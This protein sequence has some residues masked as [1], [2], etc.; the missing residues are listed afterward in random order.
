MTTPSTRLPAFLLL[1]LAACGAPEPPADIPTLLKAADAARMEGDWAAA[2]LAYEALGD[3]LGPDPDPILADRARRGSIQ[4]LA[5]TDAAG[6]LERAQAWIAEL[7]GPAEAGVSLL[8]GLAAD[9]K[10]AGAVQEALVLAEQA[11]A[12]FP[13]DAGLRNLTDRLSDQAA[14]TLTD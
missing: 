5:A 4:A 6:A 10:T 9:L 14:P 12:A 11:Q 2:G 8:G 3:A 1:A 7:G 13:S